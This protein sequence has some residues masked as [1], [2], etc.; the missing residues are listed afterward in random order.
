MAEEFISDYGLDGS[1]EEVFAFGR[2]QTKATSTTNAVQVI[3]PVEVISSKPHE[4][5]AQ[6]LADS[7]RAPD[8]PKALPP[9][10]DLKTAAELAAMIEFD[11]AQ[12][13]DSP[14]TGLRVTVYGATNWRAMLTIAPAAG[15]VRDPQQLRELTNQF[16]ERL[17]ERYDLA[18]E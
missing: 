8:L 3:T 7:P 5:I 10:K 12:H 9:R 1:V 11:L 14:K 13:P 2:T 15:P 17:C 16:A 6:V 4:T 18:W